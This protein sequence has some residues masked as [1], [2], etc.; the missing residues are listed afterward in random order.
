M[1]RKPARLD[2]EVGLLWQVLVK[3]TVDVLIRTTLPGRTG[4]AKVDSHARGHGE[5]DVIGHLTI[6]VPRHTATK[7]VGQ[8]RDGLARRRFD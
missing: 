2:R 1:R 6:L 7:F 3:E 8:L 5:V 4:I